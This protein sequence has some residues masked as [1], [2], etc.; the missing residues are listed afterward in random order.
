ME[1]EERLMNYQ[2]VE[3]LLFNME[4]DTIITISKEEARLF[5]EFQKRYA[6]MQLLE[7]IKAF[8]MRSA[9]LT[10]NFD[11][12]GRIASLQKLEHYKL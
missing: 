11:G 5:V 6:F 4:K 9:S 12:M 10:I 8:D 7:S 1:V 3:S 2:K